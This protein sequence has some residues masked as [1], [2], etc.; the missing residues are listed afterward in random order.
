MYR[1]NFENGLFD[2]QGTLFNPMDSSKIFYEGQWRKGE[3]YKF[4]NIRNTIA[5]MI[6]KN[7][8]CTLELSKLLF[9]QSDEKGEFSKETLT[10]L[11]EIIFERKEEIQNKDYIQMMDL[12]KISY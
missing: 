8:I 3:I 1:G 7:N 4:D 5:A 10:K 2:G 9:H 12:L 11:V 6:L